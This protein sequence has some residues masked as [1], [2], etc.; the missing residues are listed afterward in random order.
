MFS[1]HHYKKTA[2]AVFLYLGFIYANTRRVKMNI[3]E[4]FELNMIMIIAD[5]DYPG[6]WCIIWINNINN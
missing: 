4:K 5:I 3:R 1:Y 6:K 2:S